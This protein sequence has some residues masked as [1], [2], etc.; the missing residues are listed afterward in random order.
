MLK[1]PVITLTTDFGLKD[2][3]VGLIKGVM[4]GINPDAL[5]VDITHNVSRHNIFEASQVISM[6][7][8]YFPSAS[9]H[10]VVVDPG[11]GGGRRPILVISNG[12][13]FIGPDNGVFLHVIEEAD[14]GEVKVIHLT[15]S[16]H[17]LHMSGSTFH[18]RDIFA[19]V[20]AWLSKG[21]DIHKFGDEITDYVKIPTLRATIENGNLIKGAVVYIDN[22][23]NA[24]TNIRKEKV[25]DMKAG[26]SDGELRVVYKDMRLPMADYYEDS[27]ASGDKLSSIIN[28]FGLVELYSFKDSAAKKF[29][30]SIGDEV[31]VI[32]D[33]R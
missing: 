9:I 8:G 25:E 33:S 3:F 26:T 10:V 32:L 23:G 16:H 30:M 14:A 21:I 12:H 5:I 22:F 17:F 29:N 20:A 11:V 28:S 13:Y 6:S 4:L 24:I 31:S 27:P 7:Y 19:P 1:R 2:P 15:A 18:G